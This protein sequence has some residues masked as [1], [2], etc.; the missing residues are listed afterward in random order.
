M[1]WDWMGIRN[2]TG[3]QFNAHK[4][5]INTLFGWT[6]AEQL[7][8]WPTGHKH[9]TNQ[10]ENYYN[11]N[12]TK[13]HEIVNQIDKHTLRKSFNLSLKLYDF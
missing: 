13:Q 2:L 5:G 10:T 7:T 6:E 12:K 11:T 8:P 1:G 4:R 3:G 9:K